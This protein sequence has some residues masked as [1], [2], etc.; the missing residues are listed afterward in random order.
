MA[1]PAHTSASATRSPIRGPTT[2]QSIF[3]IAAE[4]PASTAQ[5]T[6]L[7]LETV[8]HPVRAAGSLHQRDG[9]ERERQVHDVTAPI[10]VSRWRASTPTPLESDANAAPSSAATEEHQS[11]P[12]TPPL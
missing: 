8:L 12:P 11:T 9:E 10:S 7:Y 3:C 5:L 4:R 1:N 6:G 2:P